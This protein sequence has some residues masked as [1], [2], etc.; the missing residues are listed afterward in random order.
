MDVY[1]KVDRLGTLTYSDAI[2]GNISVSVLLLITVQEPNKVQ[3]K[4]NTPHELKKT[5]FLVHLNDR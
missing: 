2:K 3:L 1:N 4:K 5:I